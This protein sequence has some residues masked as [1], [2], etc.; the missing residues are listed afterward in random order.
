MVQLTEFQSC[1]IEDPRTAA[2]LNGRRKRS[3]AP[4]GLK[5]S[6]GRE[7]H[8][9]NHPTYI[10]GLPMMEYAR[11]RL[12]RME[13]GERHSGE[14]QKVA[15][16]KVM[17]TRTMDGGASDADIHASAMLRSSPDAL[18]AKASPQAVTSLLN[19]PP[20]ALPYDTTSPG[21]DAAETQNQDDEEADQEAGS[22]YPEYYY[23]NNY[24]YNNEYEYREHMYDYDSDGHDGSGDGTLTP[25]EGTE[26]YVEEER[27]D[28]MGAAA[29]S[30]GAHYRQSDVGTLSFDRAFLYAVRHN[31]T[32]L[33]LFLGRYLD[34]QAN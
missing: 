24:N 33:L 28:R 23:Y 5:V 25:D 31:P 21:G 15:P 8:R 14:T 17:S 13:S 9:S 2:V 22:T 1:Q 18:K 26:D 10:Y 6:N 20:N 30:P 27:V 34:P 12:T 19:T 29:D 16:Q 4:D 3:P 11:E 32:G 7:S